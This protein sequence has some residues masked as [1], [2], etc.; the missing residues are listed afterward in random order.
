MANAVNLALQVLTVP[1]AGE[2]RDAVEAAVKSKSPT[3]GGA[4]HFNEVPSLWP[5]NRNQNGSSRASRLLVACPVQE[6][7]QRLSDRGPRSDDRRT[8]LVFPRHRKLS[9]MSVNR[10][11]ICHFGLL[12][13]IGD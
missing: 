2:P 3:V 12:G 7:P 8:H 6:M 1:S 13:A 5:R 11:L 9:E 10:N 4:S